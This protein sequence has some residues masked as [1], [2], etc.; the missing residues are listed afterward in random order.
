LPTEKPG[1]ERRRVFYGIMRS[2]LQHYS[3]K[4]TRTSRSD[5]GF[6]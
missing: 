3:V 5:A 2:S 1:A 6:L 4:K